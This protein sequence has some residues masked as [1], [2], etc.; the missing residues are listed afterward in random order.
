MLTTPDK[1][2][3][4]DNEMLLRK[5]YLSVDLDNDMI[6][7]AKPS[8][9]LLNRYSNDAYWPEYRVSKNIKVNENQQ[10]T[11]EMENI[12]CKYIISFL[13]SFILS[14]LILM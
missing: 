1:L 3:C 13:L 2:C 14:Y 6:D 11:Y 9:I 7:Y 8:R 10:E 5:N 12:I 4:K